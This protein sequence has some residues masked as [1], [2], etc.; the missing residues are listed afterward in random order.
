MLDACMAD[1]AT[2]QNLVAWFEENATRDNVDSTPTLFIDGVKYSNMSYQAL[3][4][5]LDAKLAD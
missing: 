1:G 4:E 5:I 3:A 2:A